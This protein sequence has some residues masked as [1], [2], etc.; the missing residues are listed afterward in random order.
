[1]S[2][3]ARRLEPT[4]GRSWITSGR[5]SSSGAHRSPSNRYAP[6]KN[7]AP[8]PLPRSSIVS[9]RDAAPS[10]PDAIDRRHRPACGAGRMP[11]VVLD[12]PADEHEVAGS[13]RRATAG[14]PAQRCASPSTIPCTAIPKEGGYVMPQ[15]PRTV[16]CE[17][18]APRARERCRRSVSTSIA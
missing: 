13:T 18:A 6:Q 2:I 4:F 3:V 10:A 11:H 7:T 5:P 15:A 8:G 14:S 16:E 12:G 9:L 17:N 1:M